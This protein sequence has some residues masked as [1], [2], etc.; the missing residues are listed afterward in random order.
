MDTL[1]NLV[2]IAALLALALGVIGCLMV[3][4]AV[5]R[6]RR[7]VRARFGAARRRQGEQ[8]LSGVSSARRAMSGPL[9]GQTVDWLLPVRS[10]AG[11]LASVADGRLLSA[12]ALLPGPTRAASAVG[13]DLHREVASAAF[14]V[15]AAR[16]AGRPVH[17]LESSVA[18]LAEQARILQLDLRVV[19]AEPDSVARAQLLSAHEARATLIRGACAEVRAAVLSGGSASSEPVLE[20]IVSD[21]NDAALAVRLRAAA[22]R[23]LSRP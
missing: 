16:R 17:E 1:L 3:W 11:R 21:V 2:L 18:M 13:R 6:L 20:G 5:R 8:P 22:Y 12:R 10:H 14:A 7:S 15:R 23:E 4:R 9:G 19:A